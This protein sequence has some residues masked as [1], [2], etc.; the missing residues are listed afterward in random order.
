MLRSPDKSVALLP[1]FKTLIPSLASSC[2]PV[3]KLSIQN[4]SLTLFA[5]SLLYISV[6]AQPFRSS[7]RLLKGLSNFAILMSVD[8]IRSITVPT[9]V[10]FT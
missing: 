8:P 10:L 1:A 3:T 7:N 6:E 2:G 4:S 5:I 9:T